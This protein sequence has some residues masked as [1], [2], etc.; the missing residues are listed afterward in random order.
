MSDK[1]KIDL[2]VKFDTINSFL[3]EN[4]LPAI[5]NVN[6]TND[7]IK[8][9]DDSISNPITSDQLKEWIAALKSGKYE[10]GTDTLHYKDNSIERYCCLGVFCKIN[11]KLRISDTGSYFASI[12]DESEKRCSDTLL[13]NNDCYYYISYELQSILITL[14]DDHSNNDFKIISNLLETVILP[15]LE[16]YENENK[17]K[18]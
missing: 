5:N 2:N 7:Y 17:N 3:K 9:W 11:D 18:G 13:K 8:I 12:D 16:K 14:N 1:N 10:H 15:V 4:G 6:T